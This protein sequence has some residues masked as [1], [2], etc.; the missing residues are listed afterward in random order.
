M[1]QAVLVAHSYLTK[2]VELIFDFFKSIGEARQKRKIARETFR[3]LSKLNDKELRDI[4][5]SRGDIW[6]IAHNENPNLKG[7]V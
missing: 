4:G 3:E 6:Y 5:I 1:T 2:T 7:W